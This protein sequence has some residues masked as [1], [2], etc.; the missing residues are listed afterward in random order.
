MILLSNPGIFAT[1][2]SSE[3]FPIEDLLRALRN[4]PVSESWAIL[5]GDVKHKS[6][7]ITPAKFPVENTSKNQCQRDRITVDI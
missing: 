1:D 7:S 3:D 2:P 6:S 4:P 5:K